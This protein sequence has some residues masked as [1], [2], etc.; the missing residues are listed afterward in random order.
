MINDTSATQLNNGEQNNE[1][2]VVNAGQQPGPASS[3]EI[4]TQEAEEQWYRR[5]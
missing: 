4:P 3:Q 2:V 5:H 1:V